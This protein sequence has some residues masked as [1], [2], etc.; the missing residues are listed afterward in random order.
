LGNFM[1]ER[2]YTGIEAIQVCIK[3]TLAA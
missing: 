3:V 1:K 2:R